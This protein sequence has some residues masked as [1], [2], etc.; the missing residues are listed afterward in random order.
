MNKERV[1]IV[2]CCHPPQLLYVARKL[3]QQHP[4]WALDALL[5]DSPLNRAHF[6][7][8]SLFESVHYCSRE[9]PPLENAP[10]RL[11]FPMLNRGY[12]RLVRL[13]SR[14]KIPG[15]K[16]GYQGRLQAVSR[17]DYPRLWL[18]PP[19]QPEEFARFLKKFPVQP[20]GKRVLLVEGS[21]GLPQASRRRW[22]RYLPPGADVT[23]VKEGSLWRNWRRLRGQEFEGAVT[24]FT[25]EAGFQLLR[26]LPFVLGIQRTIVVD[27]IAECSVE[28]CTTL[29]RLVLNRILHPRAVPPSL[30]LVLFVQTESV[31]YLIHS[32]RKLQQSNLFPKAE[33]AVL[34][35]QDDRPQ[36]ERELKDC[37]FLSHPGRSLRS[38]LELWNGAR[39]LRPDAVCANFTGRGAFRRYKLLF[40]LINVRRR[41]A[42]NAGLEFYPLTL[43]SLPRIFRKEKLL[44]EQPLIRQAP[45]TK[46]LVLQTDDN[47]RMAQLMERLEDPQV[48]GSAP[49]Y[50]FCSEANRKF[51]ESLPRVEEVLTYRKGNRRVNLSTLR[52]LRQMHP[53]AVVAL[54]AGRPTFRR[55]KLLF[56]L[57]PARGR[58]VFN[59][60]LECYYLNSKTWRQLLKRKSLTASSSA[61][62]RLLLIQS[63]DDHTMLESLGTVQ[64]PNLA[65]VSQL[66]VFCRED[67]QKLFESRPEVAQ[68]IV[69]RPGA[70]VENLRAVRR[71]RR[72]DL[73]SVCAVF[74]GRPIFRLQK[75]LF[76]L[77]P[78]RHRLVINENQDCFYFSWLRAGQLLRLHGNRHL[79]W[80]ELVFRALLKGALFFPRF[81]YLVIWVTVMKLK[82]AYSLSLEDAPGR[83]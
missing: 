48:A 33:M 35:R 10:D 65:R 26:F 72:L 40:F 32:V 31:P 49:I 55:A 81:F 76:F 34:C 25:A 75:L 45:E 52:R 1:L 38:G 37:Q 22:S 82:R 27:E 50:V 28:R 58:L 6:Q 11:V 14:L 59:A 71:L 17:L 73:D 7:D 4:D 12:L 70:L 62:H 60:H 57:L 53:D 47:S 43:R 67:K 54:L 66:L 23:R 13:A 51:F 74:S 19:P 18:K 69:Y 46:V 39:Q 9:L 30:P 29:A 15:W 78:A 63:E 36:L 64:G 2:Q 56:F 21:F 42:F 5:V 68:V 16:C 8:T 83:D 61:P 3:R 79:P 41:I 77:A 24:F 20:L 44:F 80:L